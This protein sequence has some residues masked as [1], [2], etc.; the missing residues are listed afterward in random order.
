MDQKGS[1]KG[2]KYKIIIEFCEESVESDHLVY[3][4]GDGKITLR[5]IPR[6]HSAVLS[7]S[8]KKGAFFIK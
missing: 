6:K 2:G 4:R 8:T 1:L 3:Q 5:R 7:G